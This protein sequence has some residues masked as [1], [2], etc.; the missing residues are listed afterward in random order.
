MQLSDAIAK[1]SGLDQWE[2]I[3][4]HMQAELNSAIADFQNADLIDTPQRLARLSGE[5]AALDRLLRTF[6]DYE[7]DP[8]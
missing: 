6:Q 5:I 7:S 3:L 4:D 8:A 2:A 1:L